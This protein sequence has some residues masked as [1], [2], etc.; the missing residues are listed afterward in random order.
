MMPSRRHRVRPGGWRLARLLTA[1]ALT[2]ALGLGAGR[3]HAQPGPPPVPDFPSLSL[4]Y[5]DPQGPGSASLIPQGPDEATG[6]TALVVSI[7][8]SG[9]VYSGAGLVRRVGERDYLLA[10]GLRDSSGR[11]YFFAGTLSSDEEGVRWRGRGR[12]Q[13]VGLPDVSGEWHM[14]EWPVIE[15]PRPRLVASVELN[16]VE[17]TAVRG[18][19][20]LVALPEG[21]TR[22]ELQLAGLV[23]GTAYSIQLHAGTPAEASA[24]FTALATVEADA[25]GRAIASGLVRSR[26][27]EAIPLAD[28]ADGNH[29]ITV[30]GAGQIVA[31]GVIP[32]LEPLA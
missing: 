8:Q 1:L 7:A 25:A 14:A 5:S 2:V 17:D 29:I 12:Y 11:S 23:P 24:S 27:A 4:S 15:A 16:P 6:G 26:G 10:A 28:I 32:A 31:I 19:V 3:A 22:F 30:V 20:T 18:A 9:G 13:E 21:E